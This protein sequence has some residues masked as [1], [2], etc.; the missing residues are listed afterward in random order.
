[1]TSDGWFVRLA[2]AL[3]ACA[4]IGAPARAA[5][6]VRVAVAANFTAPAK[7]I[8]EAFE[9]ESGGPVILSFGSTGQLFTQIAHG[10]PYDVF[11]AADSVRPEKAV[12][13]GLAVA[14]SRFTYATGTLVLYSTDPGLVTGPETLSAGTFQK[15][16]IANPE[17]A[18]Y[19][20]AAVQVL[21]ALGVYGEIAPRLVRGG[22]IAQTYQ[23]VATSAA[24][25][26]FVALSQVIDVTDGSRWQVPASL[27]DPIAQDAVLL[28]EGEASP[29]A[30]AFLTFL[31]GP[32][33]RAVIERYGYGLVD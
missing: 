26:G 28:S 6:E 8:A 10:A 9:R 30:A 18:P 15:L 24:E 4:A 1:M 13:D 23:F 22:S 14:G 33:A 17:T 12:A 16:A 27:H 32:Q 19:G 31:K 29:A 21:E 2:L 20:A 3:V 25:L 7:E 11:L 5:G